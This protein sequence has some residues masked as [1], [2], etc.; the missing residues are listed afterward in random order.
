[1][2]VPGNDRSAA[3]GGSL[4]RMRDDV[5]EPA[6]VRTGSNEALSID[7]TQE[8]ACSGARKSAIY[9]PINMSAATARHDRLA[10]GWPRED[11]HNVQT[12]QRRQTRRHDVL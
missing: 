7:P 4:R 1:M 3:T 12:P 11:R 9:R 10:R 5:L 2:G 6:P 8:I